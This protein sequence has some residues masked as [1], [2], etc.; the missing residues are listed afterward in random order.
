MILPIFSKMYISNILESVIKNDAHLTIITNAAILDLI[1]E[2]D[3]EGRFNSLVEEERIKVILT[4]YD[5]EWFFS[6]CDNFSSLFLFFNERSFD[7]S[8]MLLLKDEDDI[9]DAINLFN[10]FKDEF[11]K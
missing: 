1:H 6:A 8:E 4:D 2:N 3:G 7:V 10:Y 11:S 9:K 5:L